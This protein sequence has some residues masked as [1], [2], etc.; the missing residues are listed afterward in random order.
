MKATSRMKQVAL[1]SGETVLAL[2]MGTWRMGDD[3]GL[4]GEEIATLQ[5]GLDLGC[6][7]I[8]TAEMYGNGA[9][10]TLVG[11]AIAGQRDRAFLV[12]KVLPSNASRSGTVAAC[13]ASLRRLRTDWIDLY[14]LHWRGEHPLEETLA[15]LNELLERDLIRYWGVS[16]FDIDDM[17]ELQQLPGGDACA[18]NQVLYNLSRRG[19]EYDLLPH[20]RARRMPIMA[21]SP[22]EQARLAENPVLE[23][24]AS[25]HDMTPTQLALAWVL[26][27]DDVIA[28][29]KTSH[30]PRLRENIGAL[31]HQLS[32]DLLAELDQH[33]PP[34]T[35]H[36]PLEML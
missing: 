11:E 17:E 30:R 14:L 3:R 19:I 7:L 26:R 4:R 8:D 31:T 22:I 27:H 12:S 25:E 13:E 5:L 2:G 1:P 10:E 9:A 29:P 15:G 35:K 16:N 34:P 6:T 21:Y 23:E 28:I 36:V 33:F 32:P 18:T 24:L 20:S